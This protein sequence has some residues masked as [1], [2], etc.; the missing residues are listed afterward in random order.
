MF[1]EFSSLIHE[2]TPLLLYSRRW[3]SVCSYLQLLSS[4]GGRSV[5]GQI[6]KNL[7]RI[8]RVTCYLYRRSP[9]VFNNDSA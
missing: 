8:R 9:K 2:I 7:I 1:Q 5:T 4:R 6:V 3:L